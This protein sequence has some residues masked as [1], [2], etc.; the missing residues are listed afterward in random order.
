MADTTKEK[1]LKIN[2]TGAEKNVKSL[3]AQIRELKEQLAGLEKGTEE[4]NRVSKQL[5]DTNQKQIEI[6]EAMKYS[7]KD[8]GATLGNLT[9]VAAGVIGAINGINAVM[10]LMGDDSE[11]AQEAMKSVQMM[12]AVIQ[13]LS[14]IDT[15]RKS[16]E[17]LANAFSKVG[18]AKAF[19]AGN[20]GLSTT[21]ELAENAALLENTNRTEKNNLTADD[22]T[23][24]QLEN[25]SA[26]DQSTISIE[27]E[28]A[29][30][31]GQKVELDR[32]IKTL[33]TA[34]GQLQRIE[35]AYQRGIITEE[36]YIAMK[37]RANAVIDKTKKNIEEE[38]ASLNRNTGATN[39]NTESQIV[40]NTTNARGVKTTKE[41]GDASD[42]AG[43]AAKG[44]ASSFSIWA[45]A[46]A[47]VVIVVVQVVNHFKKMREEM[48]KLTADGTKIA[49]QA[50]Q[51]TAE[52]I[53]KFEILRQ[54]F[55]DAKK[56]GENMTKWIKIHNG[57][58][59]ELNIQN[60]TLNNLEDI[61]INKTDEFIEA[62]TK[63]WVAENKLKAAQ[64][65]YIANLKQINAL[66]SLMDTYG[67]PNSREEEYT[68]V[69][70]G[71]YITKTYGEWLDARNRAEYDNKKILEGLKDITKEELEAELALKQFGVTFN[72]T[73]TT[74]GANVKRTLK[75]MIGDIKS[76]YKEILGDMVKQS[77]TKN[78]FNGVY[79]ELDNL[80]KKIYQLTAGS[81][82]TK[83][84]EA[85]TSDFVEAI[86]KGFEGLDIY[87]LTVD[88][89]FD[90][91]IVNTISEELI[92]EQDILYEY[93]TTNQKGVTEEVIKQ[94]KA[95]VAA[96]TTEV[97][98]IREIM[99][100]VL[101][102]GKAEQAQAKKT[103]DI[104]K[105]NITFKQTIDLYN[106]Y[107]ADVRSNNPYKDVNK[108]ISEATY[109]LDNLRNELRELDEEESR[110]N[111]LG[112]N[113]KEIKDRLDEIANRRRELALEQFNLENDL[114]EAMYQKRL[115]KIEQ[116]MEA[117]KKAAE[118]RNRDN[119]ERENDYGIS[120]GTYNTDL[121]FLKVQEQMLENQKAA[122]EKY[123]AELIEQAKQNNEDW[124]LL[125]MEKNAAIL[126]LDRQLEEQRAQIAQEGS[127]R[128]LNI[129]KAY[130]NAYQTISTQT[131][132]I[133]SAIMDGM[134]EN[135]QEYKNMKYAQGVID[136]L[137]GTL[138]GFMS[139]VESGLPAPWNLILAAATAGSVFATG[140]IQLNNLK[141]ERL[142]NGAQSNT[143]TGNFSEYDTLSY[144][145]NSEILGNI[146]DTRV[147]V[148]ESDITSTQ[149]RVQV[150]E[151]QATF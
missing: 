135:S 26:T 11:A 41:L 58:M 134:D 100:A 65:N 138:A 151:T 8:L 2:T 111:S 129:A 27:L 107:R 122:A 73:T 149:N 68:L 101:A 142:A 115:I 46:I 130:V 42:K 83:V 5:A 39:V 80:R 94:Q 114:E 60:T 105:W 117:E 91:N 89:V 22:Y 133:M 3:K 28:N 121:N 66:Q 125:E 30:L 75:E 24:K 10:V 44:A 81:I 136:T 23:K 78:M 147:Y 85:F 50:N 49:T 38:T 40:N 124:K 145:Q 106:K 53:G 110:L 97:N 139:G 69:I 84:G 88:K 15:A 71:E 86:E 90:S 144:M 70:D 116:L 17:G 13:G 33:E 104:E 56:A 140:M 98:T 150:A 67:V 54:K 127:R 35:L 34:E 31:E 43:K 72:N 77:E 37:E 1:I 47:A 123:Y 146:Q 99:D 131:L 9:N 95:K 59:K 92:K 64:E 82:G 32:N 132:N 61:F 103:K 143:N 74:A 108:S 48:R 118:Q 4:Y 128:R 20:T 109:S 137:S 12:M 18:Q 112:I 36:Q 55:V 96:L 141:H 113:N 16:L 7:N 14:S 52:V 19:A 51:D 93:L 63:R 25:A 57:E 87:G 76:L 62:L 119:E 21:S 45:M 148:V 29:A 126:E 6:N 120:G 102:L 79:D